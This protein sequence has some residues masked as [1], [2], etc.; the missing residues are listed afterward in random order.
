MTRLHTVS[1]SLVAA[2]MLFLASPASAQH[3][4]T[5]KALGK[6]GRAHQ[7]FSRRVQH[8][9]DYSRDLQTHAAP[10]VVAAKPV[11]PK[12]A[13]VKVVIDEL[14]RNLDAAEAHLAEMKK[15]AADDKPT[16]AAIEKIEKH[17]TTAFD[18]HKAAHACMVE[19]FDS[20]KAL[21]CCADLSKE[22]DMVTAEHNA[23]MKTLAAKKTAAAKTVK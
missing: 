1:L 8:A 12:P 5:W 2:A 21:S 9:A 23:L 13:E 22:L 17:L 18:H 10:L 15:S 20:A 14:G 3:D 16:L 19:N 4:A 6:E 11:A 7:N